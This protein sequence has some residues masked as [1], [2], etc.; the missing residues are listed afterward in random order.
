MG[1]GM[2]RL[3]AFVLLL[4]VPCSLRAGQAFEDFSPTARDFRLFEISDEP[5][6]TPDSTER[7]SEIQAASRWRSFSLDASVGLIGSKQTMWSGSVGVAIPLVNS[8][9][10]AIRAEYNMELGASR[11]YRPQTRAFQ[12]EPGVRFHLD[13]DEYVAFFTEHGL[14]VG[15]RLD[16]FKLDE[17]LNDS[18]RGLV[19]S[20]GIGSVNTI[21]LEFGER[22]WRGYVTSGL[23]TQFMIYQHADEDVE[24]FRDD[25]RDGFRFQWLVFRAGV[26]LYF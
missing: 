19:S 2:L 15:Y 16:Y 7:F 13:F 22:T 17:R 3:T 24:G 10:F 11:T 12:L 26:R 9:S 20:L 21:G 14:S 23:R 25:I 8:L 4:C 5:A 6:S 1:A 18:D